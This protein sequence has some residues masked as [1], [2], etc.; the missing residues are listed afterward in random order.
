L[1]SLQEDLT[2]GL[3]IT[4]PTVTKT[5]T[6]DFYNKKNDL[7]ELTSSY[8]LQLSLE[9]TSNENFGIKFNPIMAPFIFYLSDGYKIIVN[10]IHQ[11]YEA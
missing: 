1:K 9:I 4:A 10:L 5:L 7:D 8:L 6:V 11:I 3:T 2:D